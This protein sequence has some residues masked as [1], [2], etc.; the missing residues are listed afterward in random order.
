MTETLESDVQGFIDSLCDA[1]AA[2]YRFYLRKRKNRDT[3]T[4]L[5]LTFREVRSRLLLLRTR[6]YVSGPEDDRDRRFPGEVWK[7]RLKVGKTVCYIK[8]KLEEHNRLVKCL[9]FH[10]AEHDLETPFDEH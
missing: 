4:R 10:E 3:I 7:F 2:G 1:L 5:G 9:S 8:L 6:D